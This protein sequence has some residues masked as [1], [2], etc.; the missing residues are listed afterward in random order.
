MLTIL[1]ANTEGGNAAAFHP[2]PVSSSRRFMRAVNAGDLQALT[3]DQKGIISTIRHIHDDENVSSE[4]LKR[5]VADMY[6]PALLFSQEVRDLPSIYT[7]LRAFLDSRGANMTL[8]S[9]RRV[10][11]TPATN[12]YE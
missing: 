5:T 6:P 10:M 7:E 1:G 3:S 4:N 12:L 2:S 11:M 8:H 9:S